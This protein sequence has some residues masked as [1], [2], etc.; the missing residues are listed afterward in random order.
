MTYA[1]FSMLLGAG[2]VNPLINGMEYTPHT[3]E[4]W[5]P[6]S[7]VHKV[8]HQP[9]IILCYKIVVTKTLALSLPP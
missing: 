3:D 4:H 7:V 8:T 5:D 2:A 1:F 6:F 9:Q